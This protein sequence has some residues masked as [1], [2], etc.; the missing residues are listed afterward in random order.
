MSDLPEGWAMTSLGEIVTLRGEKV[1]P[2]FVPESQFIGLEDIEPHT[3]RILKV[4]QASDVRSAVARFDRGDLLYSRLRPY[5]NKVV[6]APFDGVA[7]AEILVLQPTGATKAEFVRR[8]IMAADFLEFAALLDKGDRPRV[9]YPEISHFPIALP[10]LLEQRRIVA[11]VDGITARSARARKELNRIPVLIARY[12]QRLLALAAGGDLTRGWRLET[13]APE[14]TATSVEDAAL[15]T[16]DGPFGSN[17]KSADYVERGV[18]VVRLENIG[19]LN[20]IREKET[21]ISTEKYR[22]L[23]RHT[24]APGDVLFSSFIADEI[25]VCRLPDDLPTLAINKADCFCVRPDTSK[26]L[27]AFLA[28]RLASPISYQELKDAVHGATRPRISLSYLKGYIFDLPSVEEQAEIV[29]RIDSAFDWLDRV[30]ADHAVAARLLPKLDAAI[31]AK[32]FRGELVPQDPEDESASVLLERIR[33]ERANAPKARRPRKERSV[34]GGDIAGSIVITGDGNRVTLPAIQAR[35]PS[36][37]RNRHDPE[38]MGQ[39]YLTAMLRDK[40]G[41]AQPETLFAEAD[42]ELVDFYKQLSD[43]FDRGW[44]V[45]DGGW[46]KAAA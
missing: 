3:S 31:L 40:S 22:G 13:G 17:L 21:Y 16:F 11:K 24:L 9:N 29:R 38:V 20:F 25:R 8:R 37:T 27:S 1:S 19:S 12:K 2:E 28:Y 45:D 23:K 10:P 46:L 6:V 7:S 32:A 35:G 41:S 26:C 14:W 39:P 15:T 44:I 5:L 42:L 36:M 33:A 4:G 18:R 30:A 34:S 43:E